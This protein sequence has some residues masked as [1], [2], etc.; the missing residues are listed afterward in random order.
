[1]GNR[2]L[3]QGPGGWE[4]VGTLTHELLQDRGWWTERERESHEN[5]EAARRAAGKLRHSLEFRLAMDDFG[6]G[7]VDVAVVRAYPVNYD[8]ASIRS[9]LQDLST[10]PEGSAV[11][12]RP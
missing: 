5:P 8:Q 3:E 7:D 4:E 1:M 12:M 2:L 11:F 6:T 10:S 9:F